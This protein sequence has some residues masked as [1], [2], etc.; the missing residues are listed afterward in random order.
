MHIS[1]F[2]S[3]LHNFTANHGS[4][5]GITASC[6]KNEK[7]EKYAQKFN[8][9]HIVYEGSCRREEIRG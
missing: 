7:V 9:F 4:N 8:F 6:V 2:L 5:D 1:Q 3:S